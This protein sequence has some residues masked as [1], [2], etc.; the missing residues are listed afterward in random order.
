MTDHPQVIAA[1]AALERCRGYW[2]LIASQSGLS[3]SWLSKFARGEANNP[4]IGSLQAVVDACE[5]V[6]N[7]ISKADRAF[8]ALGDGTRHDGQESRR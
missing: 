8:A 4:T 3:Y 6:H 1:R 7:A 5:V 2:N